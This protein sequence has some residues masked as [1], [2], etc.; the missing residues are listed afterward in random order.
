M[1]TYLVLAYDGNYVGRTQGGLFE[2]FT[3][4]GELYAADPMTDAVC[5]L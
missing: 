3:Y 2:L 5:L 1:V 4:G